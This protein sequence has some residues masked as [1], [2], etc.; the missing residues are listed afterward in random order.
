M[1]NLWD[2]PG[3][4]V[5]PSTGEVEAGGSE[6]QGHPLLHSKFKVGLDSKTTKQTNKNTSATE[7]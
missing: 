6:V 1:F 2:K 3:I 4:V 5:N 7:A